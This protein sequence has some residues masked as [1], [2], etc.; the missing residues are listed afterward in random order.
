MLKAH[1]GFIEWCTTQ[2]IFPL[3]TM[4]KTFASKLI[5]PGST[6]QENLSNNDKLNKECE[7]FSFSGGI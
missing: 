1:I 4:T 2:K 7:K 6:E 5:S 3:N